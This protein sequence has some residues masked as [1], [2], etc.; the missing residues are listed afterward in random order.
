MAIWV[1]PMRKASFQHGGSRRCS[2]KSDTMT[3][4]AGLPPTDFPGCPTQA[5]RPVAKTLMAHFLTTWLLGATVW[6]LPS[7]G[8]SK[9]LTIAVEA[10]K[11]RENKVAAREQANTEREE[12]FLERERELA[13]MSAALERQ[14]AEL[15]AQKQ[16]FL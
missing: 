4:K 2:K 8:D 3:A 11:S 7:C 14:R 6:M 12:Q 15:E 9:D 5:L 13:A 16:K 1:S 10:L